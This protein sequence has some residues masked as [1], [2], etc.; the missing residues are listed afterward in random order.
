MSGQAQERDPLHHTW[1]MRQRFREAVHHLRGNV[2]K[3]DGPRLKAMFETSA[4]ALEGWIRAFRDHERKEEPAWR[5]LAPRLAG[6]R[7]EMDADGLRTDKPGLRPGD[8]GR[9]GEN[10]SPPLEW[11]GVPA[12][13]RGFLPIPEDPDAPSGPF[14]HWGLCNLERD[15]TRASPLTGTYARG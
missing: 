12:Q 14:R 7:Q 6:S 10:L 5:G 9:D 3:V 15:R 1:R 8:P 13:A 11:T 4:E 2:G